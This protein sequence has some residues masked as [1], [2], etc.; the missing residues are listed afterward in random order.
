MLNITSVCR[1]VLLYRAFWYYIPVWLRN[2]YRYFDVGFN[3]SISDLNQ[4][5]YI[6][7]TELPE[8]QVEDGLLKYKNF[9][10]KNVIVVH[11]IHGSEVK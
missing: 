3:I 8:C 5:R 2:S 1:Q 6:G 9:C 7:I 4:F 11:T 10:S